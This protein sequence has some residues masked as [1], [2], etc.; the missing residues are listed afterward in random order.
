LLVVAQLRDVFAAKDSAVMSQKNQHGRLLGP[1][2]AKANIL[3]ITIGKGDLC[4][5]AAERIFHALSILSSARSTVKR[6]ASPLAFGF[7]AD[8]CPFSANEATL[9]SN[10]AQGRFFDERHW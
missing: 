4:E 10:C 5:A 9:I 2:R 3:P 7:T 1:Q 8:F 6:S